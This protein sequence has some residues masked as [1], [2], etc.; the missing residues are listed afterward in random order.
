MRTREIKNLVVRYMKNRDFVNKDI[1]KAYY[2]AVKEYEE[3][4]SKEIVY[5][6]NPTYVSRN[7]EQDTLSYS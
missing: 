4:K 3:R 7:A 2:K 6:V 5:Y 1:H